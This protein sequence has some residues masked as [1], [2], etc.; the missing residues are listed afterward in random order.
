[1]DDPSEAGRL[2]SLAAAALMEI[3]I[4]EPKGHLFMAIQGRIATLIIS[5]QP[6]SPT[7]LIILNDAIA[8]YG[9]RVL[10]GPYVESDSGVLNSIAKARDRDALEDYTSRQKFD[11]TPATDDRPF[12]FN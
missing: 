3:G 12:F 5:R 10:V 2:L 4:S 11:L 1:P 7:D 8:F 9:Y 6:F